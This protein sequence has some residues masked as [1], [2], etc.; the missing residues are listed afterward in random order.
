[1]ITAQYTNEGQSEAAITVDGITYS[2]CKPSHWQWADMV[3]AGVTPEPYVA[4]PPSA[5]DV[6]VRAG[7]IILAA[8]SET[9]QR[10]MLM[11]G[12]KLERKE[13]LQGLT[14]DEQAEA[15][16]LDAASGWI[17]AVRAHSNAMEAALEAGSAVDVESGAIDGAGGW[18]AAGA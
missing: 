2:G 14:A 6:K 7:Q 12:L 4:P 13:R 11:R 15:A 18:P 10:N 8:A 17:E 1:M 9:Q 5:A 3:R 16:A